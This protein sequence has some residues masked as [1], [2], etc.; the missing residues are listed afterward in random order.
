LYK[1]LKEN[2][3]PE[4]YQDVISAYLKILD[5][6]KSV[7][8]KDQ[9]TGEEINCGYIPKELED[10]WIEHQDELRLKGKYICRDTNEKI[11][12]HIQGN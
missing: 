2:A 6:T 9:L 4:E 1:W 11:W 5:S 12:N 8:I 10:F 3:T 7:K